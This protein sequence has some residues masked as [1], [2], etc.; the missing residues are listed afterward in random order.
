MKK[1]LFLIVLA[2]IVS[3]QIFGQIPNLVT[4]EWPT[5]PGEAIL[6]NKYKVTLEQNGQTVSSQVICSNSKDLD[7]PNFAQE[8]RGGRTFNWT[9]FSYN[10]NSPVKIIVEDLFSTTVNDVEIFPST[11]NISKTLSADKKRV[12]FT[13][14]ESK[15]VSVNFKST[16]NTHTS[17]GVIK[18][19]LMIFAD[20]LE[21]EI[22]SKTATGTHVY[23][24]TST[25]SDLA[26]A[27]VLYFPKGYHD[28]SRF[29]NVSNIGPIIGPT[30]GDARNKTIY[31]EGGAYV[32]GR[33]T[34]AKMNY[35]KILG[36]G[37][38]IGRDF[39]WSERIAPTDGGT[40]N[41]GVLGV[42]SFEP[43]EAHVGI[44]EGNG[45]NN[46]IDGVIVCD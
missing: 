13:L 42:N 29:G 1:I 30:N 23:S 20:K 28:L 46:Y 21:T 38:L 31:F 8:M 12:E 19:M 45:G 3:S 27:K 39:K 26:N 22:P 43:G 41:G 33:I 17:D 5:A 25:A 10:Y 44:G 24:A 32:H 40:P 37:V 18:H 14:S 15:Y 7:I 16:Q 9:M 36:R 2:I 4:Y 11:F 35:T 6:S 34:K